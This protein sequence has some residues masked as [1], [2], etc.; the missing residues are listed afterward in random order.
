MRPPF[1][2]GQLIA[3]RHRLVEPADAPVVGER[4]CATGNGDALVTLLYPVTDATALTA[5]RGFKHPHATPVRDAGVDGDTAWVV[6]GPREGRP[7]R[8]WIADPGGAPLRDVRVV[9]DQLTQCLAAAHRGVAGAPLTHGGPLA[10][11]VAIERRG[12]QLVASLDGLGLAAALTRAP[13]P[14]DDVHALGLLLA[15][16]LSGEDPTA[17]QD[18]PAALTRLEALR[19]E[20]DPSL[21]AIARACTDADARPNA[22]RVREL[23]RQAVWT[24][25]EAPE[26]PPPPPP[27]SSPP[28]PSLPPAEPVR[29]RVVAV[30]VTP[31]ERPATLPPTRVTPP[32]PAPLPAPPPPAEEPAAPSDT[33]RAPRQPAALRDDPTSLVLTLPQEGGAATAATGTLIPRR[34]FAPEVEDEA[35]GIVPVARDDESTRAIE[36]VAQDD[37]T[38]PVVAPD[39][40]RA[41]LRAPS[42]RPSTMPPPMAPRASLPSLPAPPPRAS[43]P[44][45]PFVLD[46]PPSPPEPSRAPAVA[47]AALLLCGA[48]AILWVALSR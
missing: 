45:R 41:T 16:L 34:S 19:P 38:A 31:T 39:D 18:L 5:L 42:S 25:R 12:T 1:A 29:A 4:W 43:E 2:A 15:E 23:L 32:P 33:V 14:A 10:P 6:T 47:A 48:L 27:P 35:T 28:P 17:R 20:V 7:L 3:S 8:A 46:P 24:P 11:S 21:W 9:V 44:P 40:V 22:A 36:L 26:A 30:H 13:T 37:P